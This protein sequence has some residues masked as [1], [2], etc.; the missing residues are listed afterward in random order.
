MSVQTRLVP[1]LAEGGERTRRL[2]SCEHLLCKGTRMN[3]VK[4]LT[5][6]RDRPS[7]VSRR[8]TDFVLS[9]Q[10]VSDAE[11]TRRLGLLHG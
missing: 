11:P 8:G 4:S 6:R 7:H 3:S 2:E 10:M 1:R 9:T 5:Y